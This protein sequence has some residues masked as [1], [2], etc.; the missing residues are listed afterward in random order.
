MRMRF[1]STFP[2]IFFLMLMVG[3]GRA[4]PTFQPAWTWRATIIVILN[5]QY[6]ARG[7]ARKLVSARI[8]AKHGPFIGPDFS[9]RSPSAG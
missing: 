2:L 1:L 5:F 7:S 3:A 6:R 4:D 8:I 9:S